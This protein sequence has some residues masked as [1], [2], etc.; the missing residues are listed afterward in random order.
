MAINP[1]S[2]FS[3]TN[4]QDISVTFSR[5][6]KV[7]GLRLPTGKIVLNFER[8]TSQRMLTEMARVLHAELVIVKGTWTFVP[9]QEEDDS[10][11]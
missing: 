9:D 3:K 1:S 5:R 2:P 10:N 7:F 11:E 4:F 8:N 6:D